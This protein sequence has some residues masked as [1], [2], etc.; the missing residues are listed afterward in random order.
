[1]KWGIFE[2]TDDTDKTDG[3]GFFCPQNTLIDTDFATTDDT[4]DTDKADGHGGAKEIITY[5]LLPITC[6]LIDCPQTTKISQIK[7]NYSKFF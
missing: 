4:D 5:Y 7:T 3:H 1:M 2:T 6:Y